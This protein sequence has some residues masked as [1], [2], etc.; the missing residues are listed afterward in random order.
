MG[1]RSDSSERPEAFD[2]RHVEHDERIEG[3]QGGR[4]LRG[5]VDQVVAEQEGERRG[6]RR[7]IDDP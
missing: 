6:P 1:K 5:M 4:T 3:R 7:R 2:V